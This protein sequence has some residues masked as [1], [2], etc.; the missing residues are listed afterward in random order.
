MYVIVESGATKSDWWLVD[1]EGIPVRTFSCSGINVSTMAVRD[2][3]S[4]V[5]AALA[6][7]QDSDI[8]GV[9]MY[10]AGVV[11][12]S[13]RSE[14]LSA[15]RNLTGATDIDVQDDMVGAARSLFGDGSGIVGILGTGSNTCVYDGT[16]VSRLVRSGGYI[17][18]D[19]GGAASL[20]KMF[21]SDFIK[22]EVP[23]DVASDFASSF[24][25]DYASI[26]EGVYRSASPSAYLGSLAPFLVSRKDNPYV[27]CL[28][29]TNFNS[30]IG[31]ALKKY[32]T[33]SFDVGIVGGFGYSCSDIFTPLA[34]KAGIRVTRYVKSP[35]EGLSVYHGN[36]RGKQ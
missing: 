34:Q 28:I 15:V 17:I 4:T 13:I 5:S 32:D 12:D 19:E 1:E 7:L 16:H 23:E 36:V 30:F 27:R 3:L 20:G 21:L 14:I 25:S 10:T 11:T 6:E 18:G 8:S 22:N 9:Y 24:A 26:V 2:V 33:E 31:R 29:E 35:I